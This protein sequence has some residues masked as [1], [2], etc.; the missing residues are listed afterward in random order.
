VTVLKHSQLLFI[1]EGAF[2]YCSPK[3]IRIP[4]SIEA[5]WKMSFRR[6]VDILRV[7]IVSDEE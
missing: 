4:A 1:H 7:T 5:I 2:P 6:Q 3:R